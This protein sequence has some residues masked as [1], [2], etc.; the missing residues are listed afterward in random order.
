MVRFI[1]DKTV[2]VNK[3]R[4]D[5]QPLFQ[6][7]FRASLTNAGLECVGLIYRPDESSMDSAKGLYINYLEIGNTIIVP[8]FGISDLS[9]RW[10]IKD[11]CADDE[12]AVILIKHLFQ[13]HSIK[14]IDC[15]EIAPHGG[16]LNCIS[17]KI[18][19]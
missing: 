6:K 13:N 9:N 8:T 19:R 11:E 3:Y 10:D 1:D 7:E 17:W 14:L 15:N 16:L 4:K 18:R 2:M 12:C 5:Y